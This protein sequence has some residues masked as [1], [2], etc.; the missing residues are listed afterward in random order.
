MSNVFKNE[1]LNKKVNQEEELV[2]LN[3][4]AL[5]T[6]CEIFKQKILKWF[7][8]LALEEDKKILEFSI[9][10]K[11]TEWEMMETEPCNQY[12]LASSWKYEYE[13]FTL[14]HI[15]TKI[16]NENEVLLWLGW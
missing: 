16:D 8:E 5:K 11:I 14:L 9:K 3:H 10:D 1:E 6:I 12:Q 15:M 2:K 7:K 13:Y 4:N